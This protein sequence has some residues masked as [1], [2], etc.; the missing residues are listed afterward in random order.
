MKLL[1]SPMTFFWK[2]VFPAIWLGGVA[3]FL[4]VG[5]YSGAG[6]RN[7]MFIIQPLIMIAFGVFLFKSLAW[8]LVDEVYD[9]GDSLVIR[10]KGRKHV[11]PFSEIKNV[12]VTTFM[13]P[14]R[15]TLRLAHRGELGEDVAFMPPRKFSLNPFA[16][17]KVA[18]DLI[19]RVDRARRGIG[20]DAG[21]S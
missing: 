11:V 1:S 13:N 7:A 20:A 5:I 15:I 2:R 4:V 19:E 14:P 21:F 12:S 17:S 16:K 9:A 18:E 8:D 3:M 6:A 10:N